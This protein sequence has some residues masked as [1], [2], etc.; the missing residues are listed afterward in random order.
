MIKTG[1]INKLKALKKVAS[2]VYLDGEN[3]GLIL[4]PKRNIAESREVNKEIEVFVYMDSEDKITATTLKP[5][6]KV[7]EFAFLK[8]VSVNRIGAFMDW[9]LPKDL[10]V[11]FREQRQKML[12]D[13]SYII[14]IYVDEKTGRIAASSKL[15]KYLDKSPAE[16][17]PGERINLLINNRTN[18]GFNVI[19]NNAHSGLIF[20]EDIFQTVKT[21]QKLMGYI[22]KIREDNRIDVAL[23]PEGYE[24]VGA[25]AARV[26][27]SLRENKGY[28]AINDKSSP[29]RIYNTFGMSKKTFKKAVGA[30]YKKNLILIESQGIRLVQKGG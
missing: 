25:L 18:L 13:Q 20:Q 3:L 16:Y 6:A 5:A 1:K 9:G 19:I 29:D 7:G 28:L 8:V 24:K 14:Y 27:V 2:G 21:G 17:K 10:L 26:L 11:P 15:N 30:L 4:L 23:H 22:K 12:N